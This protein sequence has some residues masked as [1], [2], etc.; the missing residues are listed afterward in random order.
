MPPS[1]KR[2]LRSGRQKPPLRSWKTANLKALLALS[3]KSS[4]SPR[5]LRPASIVCGGDAT[6]ILGNGNDGLLN[7]VVP[8]TDRFGNAGNA[9]YFDGEATIDFP[10]SPSI[11]STSSVTYAFWLVSTLDGQYYSGSPNWHQSWWLDRTE[12]TAGTFSLA[13]TTTPYGQFWFHPRCDDQDWPTNRTAL[14]GGELKPQVWQHITMVR[15]YGNAF[16][17]YVDGVMVGQEVFDN[18]SP[19][20]LPAIRLGQ[21]SWNGVS[22]FVGKMDD[23][24][25]Y[26]RA[27]TPTE[28]NALYYDGPVWF[29][30]TPKPVVASSGGNV[31]L[32]ITAIGTGPLT[33]QWSFNGVELPGQTNPQL[34]LAELEANQVGVYSVMVSNPFGSTNLSVSVSM[35]DLKMFAGLVLRGAVGSSYRIEYVTGLGDTNTWQTLTN[36]TLMSSP[37]YF[38][39]V[40]SASQP[41]R[42]Y[43]AVPNN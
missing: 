8:T 41:R 27:L 40:E 43:R 29:S 1:I 16:R 4:V 17:L 22:G 39:D 2:F 18:S 6:N 10:A 24:R 35:L 37:S 12:E 13:L 7:G 3:K 23:L 38:F 19:L 21:H 32:G 36:V 25:I 28:I 30:A 31:N 34:N 5:P 33:Y 42:F 26:N 11:N 9:C 20:T 15:D 14:A